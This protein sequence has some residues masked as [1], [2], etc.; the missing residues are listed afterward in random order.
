MKYRTFLIIVC[1]PFCAFGYTDPGS[2]MMLIQGL[3]IFIGMAIAF[4]KNPIASLK[5]LWRN[6]FGNNADKEDQDINK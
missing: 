1:V 3:L 4:I 2:G 6:Y 5:S